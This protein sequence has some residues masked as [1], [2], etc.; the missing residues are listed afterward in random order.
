MPFGFNAAASKSLLGIGH[1]LSAI[2]VAL[3]VVLLMTTFEQQSI[4]NHY[5]E[6]GLYRIISLFERKDSYTANHSRKVA[7]I[8]EFIGKKAGLRGTALRNLTIAALLHD[9]GKIGVPEHIIDK[10][11][12]LTDEEFKIMKKHVNLGA[13]IFRLYPEISHLSDIVLHH[14]ER[15]DGSGYPEG[16][17]GDEIPFAAR[18]LAIAD[19]YEAL[20]ADRPYRK[21]TSPEQAVRTMASMPLDPMLLEIVKNDFQELEAM[22]RKKQEEA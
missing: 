2:S 13:E 7:L 11:D 16:L 18:I 8:S 12:K 19:V 21:A 14:H 4:R 6:D 17:K 3:L 1:Y 9:I 10:Q 22:L 15:I 20:T 5:H